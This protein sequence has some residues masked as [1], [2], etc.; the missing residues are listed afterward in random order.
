MPTFRFG[1]S[2]ST[3][4]WNVDTTIDAVDVNAA[5][6]AAEAALSQ[7]TVYAA[8]YFDADWIA[9]HRGLAADDEALRIDVTITAWAPETHDTDRDLE[10]RVVSHYLTMA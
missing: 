4:D 2:D 5:L 9:D 8:D 1:F 3:G 6:D 10:E 7:R